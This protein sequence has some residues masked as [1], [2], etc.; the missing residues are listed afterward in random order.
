MPDLLTPLPGIAEKQL[1]WAFKLLCTEDKYAPAR[2][3]LREVWTAFPS[4]DDHFIREFQ[5]DEGGAPFADW[6][7]GLSAQGARIG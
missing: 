7:D 3:M 4:P 1:H 6:F 5:T 2:D